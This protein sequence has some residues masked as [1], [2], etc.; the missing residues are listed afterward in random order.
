M[1]IY[2]GMVK[3]GDCGFILMN[4]DGTSHVLKYCSMTVQ[5]CNRKKMIYV[6][7]FHR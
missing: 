1:D 6:D 2:S 7:S 3:F 4:C 5:I